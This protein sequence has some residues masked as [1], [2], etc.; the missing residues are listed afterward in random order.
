MQRG[1]EHGIRPRPV[2]PARLACAVDGHGDEQAKS[3][4]LLRARGM[5]V[6]KMDAMGTPAPRL[7]GK[8]GE[9]NDQSPRSCSAHQP[10]QQ[11]PACTTR[12]AVVAQDDAASRWEQR[13]KR[14]QTRLR[15]FVAEQPLEREIEGGGVAHAHRAFYRR[16]AS[17]RNAQDGTGR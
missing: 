13:R 11:P 10:A 16:V 12:E 8:A 4:R 7:C 6:P 17:A 5:L 1:D 3:A 14:E 15:P 2:R 9:K